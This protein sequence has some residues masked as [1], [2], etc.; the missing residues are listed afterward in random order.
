MGYSH[1]NDLDKAAVFAAELAF[2]DIKDRRS[3]ERHAA[4]PYYPHECYEELVKHQQ[5]ADWG[6]DSQL[7]IFKTEVE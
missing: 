7:F 4:R 2:N 5:N 1:C 6:V 3:R